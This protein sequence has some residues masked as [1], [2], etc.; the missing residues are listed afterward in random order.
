VVLRKGCGC[1]KRGDGFG[2]TVRIV[3]RYLGA[4]EKGIRSDTVSAKD[5]MPKS[6]SPRCK[7]SICVL[8]LWKFELG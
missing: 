8:G 6:R 7:H 4:K 1:G 2:D 5:M 3:V